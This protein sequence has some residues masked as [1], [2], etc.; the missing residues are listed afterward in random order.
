M[1]IKF[2]QVGMPES[3]KEYINDAIY[4][5]GL[6]SDKYSRQSTKL[7]KNITGVESVLLTHS[8]TAALEMAAILI[9]IQPGDEVIM[10]SYTFVSTANAFVLRGAVPVF[11]DIREDTLNIDEKLI[12]S[13]ITDKTKAI[14]PVHYAAVGCNMDAIML[15]AK[16]NNLYVIEDAAQCVNAKYNNKHL[17]TI[18]HL[19]VLSFHHT[20]NITSGL[21]GALII[22]DDRFV[23]RAKVL[24]QK[25]TNREAF[26]DGQVD[27]YTWIDQGSSF[28][29][30]EL[31]AALLLAQLENVDNITKER[32][33][34]WDQYYSALVS[35][36][37]NN[38]LKLPFVPQNCRHNAHVFH[39]RCK[40]K[41]ERNKLI[42]GLK[43]QGVQSTFHYIPLHQ[44]HAGKKFCRTKDELINTNRVSDGL[45]RLPL[46]NCMSSSKIGKVV[47]ALQNQLKITFAAKP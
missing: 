7:L 38:C 25:G 44:S 2:N 27:K 8:C 12:E 47:N 29:M 33:A 35:L 30:P 14:V 42:A 26:L 46:H 37:K 24:W 40:N 28:M 16:K 43:E 20:K 21:G 41:L 11:V 18:G 10:P 1:I 5:S 15:L 34:V 39:L 23:E 22:N 4:C 6:G 13:A 3:A 32:L 19:G 9:D 36:E 31:S 17:G 45:L